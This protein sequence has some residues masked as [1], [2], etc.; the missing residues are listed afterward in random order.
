MTWLDPWPME[1]HWVQMALGSS[2]YARFSGKWDAE[3]IKDVPLLL[4]I[5]L[6]WHANYRAP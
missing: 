2:P 4:S 1:G 5:F 3:V 6:I